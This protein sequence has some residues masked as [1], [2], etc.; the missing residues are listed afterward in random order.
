MNLWGEYIAYLKDNPKGYWFKRKLYGW[1]W[2]PATREGWLVLFGYIAFVL[3]VILCVEKRA[4]SLFDDKTA[5][6]M[7][8]GATMLFIVIAWRTGESLH[9]QWGKRWDSE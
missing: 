4:L 6:G 1:G 2:T 3:S 8:V 7:I 9:W 5:L